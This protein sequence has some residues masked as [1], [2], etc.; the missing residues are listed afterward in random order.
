MYGKHL[1]SILAEDENS[2]TMVAS[3]HPGFVRTDIFQGL[4]PGPRLKLIT[5]LGYVL[6]KSA[7]QGA[8]TTIYLALCTPS[9]PIKEI[10]GA[11]YCGS[12]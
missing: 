3:L 4:P 8:Q 7:L 9:R 12:A 2:N 6:G 11:F 1:A 10:N 5:W